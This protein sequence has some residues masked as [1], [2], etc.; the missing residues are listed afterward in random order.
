M[1]PQNITTGFKVT[2]I[3]PTNCYRVLPKSPPHPPTLCEQTGLKFIP[4]FTPLRCSSCS[5]TPTSYS[6]KITIQYD[7]SLQGD[8]SMSANSTDD[9]LPLESSVQSSTLLCPV[10]ENSC[11]HVPFTQEVIQFTRRKEEGYDITTYGRYN[12]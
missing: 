5:L 7:D 12:F 3:Y 1:T 9:S 4:L 11:L 2:G 6:H 10:F 8:E